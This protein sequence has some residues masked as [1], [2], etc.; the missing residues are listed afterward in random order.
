METNSGQETSDSA[1]TREN[2]ENASTMEQEPGDIIIHK[3]K[4]RKGKV[5]K[6]L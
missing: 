5:Y 4:K 6:F 2:T 1:F 3:K